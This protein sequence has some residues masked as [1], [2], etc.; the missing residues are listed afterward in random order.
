MNPQQYYGGQFG[1]VES[2]VP[3][4]KN[5]LFSKKRLL[6]IAGI[7]LVL[8][9]IGLG[10]ASASGSGGKAS[11]MSAVFTKHDSAL[12]YKMFSKKQQAKIT[13][14]RWKSDVEHYASEYSG[15]KLESQ[16]K[17]KVGD[18]TITSYTYNLV[19]KSGSTKEVAWVNFSIKESKEDSGI[20]SF[21]VGRI[22][23]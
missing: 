8:L 9:V 18:A 20:D 5:S 1:S 17:R 11:F 12:A 13:P 16:T 21:K 22:A 10:V 23:K 7:F 15:Y 4:Q 3:N 2:G 14:E 19:L 6:I